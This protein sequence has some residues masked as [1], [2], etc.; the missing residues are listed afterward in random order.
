MYL[1]KKKKRVQIRTGL[2]F[3]VEN[4]KERRWG[5]DF[6]FPNESIAKKWRKPM[7]ENPSTLLVMYC[8]LRVAL[9]LVFIGVGR[10][11]L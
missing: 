9:S 10:I 2:R 8:G 3:H 7:G 4:V 11:F 5:K 1:W 6:R